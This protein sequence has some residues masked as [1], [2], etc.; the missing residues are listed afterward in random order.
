MGGAAPIPAASAY[1]IT[2]EGTSA[3]ASTCLRSNSCTAARTTSGH[4]KRAAQLAYA[5][6]DLI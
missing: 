3:T 2:F 6:Y 1:N 5:C 4:D